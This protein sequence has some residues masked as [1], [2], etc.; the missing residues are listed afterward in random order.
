MDFFNSACQEAPRMDSIFGICDD[1]NGTKAYTKTNNSHTWIA[2]V[3]NDDQKNVIFTAIDKCIIKENEEIGRGRCDGMITF[4]EHLFFIEL[5]DQAKGWVTEAVNQL[6]ST[7]KFFIEFHP[8]ASYKHR[9][10]YACNK[11]H[12]HFHEIDN[13][14]NLHFFRKYGFRLDVQA[15][16]IVI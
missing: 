2:I 8:N 1:N 4:N 15:E 12:P 13:E 11:R 10:A 6:E 14:R 5:K 3:K 9:K 16:I 7:I